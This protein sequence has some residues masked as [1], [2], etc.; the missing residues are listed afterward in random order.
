MSIVKKTHLACASLAILLL[1]G[2]CSKSVTGNTDSNFL[3]ELS[4]RS[5]DFLWRAA[6]PQTGLVSDRGKADGSGYGDVA[7]LASTRLDRAGGGGGARAH[8]LEK[9][10]GDGSA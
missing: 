5:F 2:G 7:S 8:H 10:V 9:C 3:E 6:D 4:R 1:A